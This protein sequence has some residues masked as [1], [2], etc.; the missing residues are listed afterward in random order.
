MNKNPSL[1]NPE[2]LLFSLLS[3]I[4]Q[5]RLVESRTYEFTQMFCCY[6]CYHFFSSTKGKKLIILFLGEKPLCQDGSPELQSSVNPI[7]TGHYLNQ[8]SIKPHGT[9]IILCVPVLIR[10][11]YYLW[12]GY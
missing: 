4:I 1:V 9:G 5:A 12:L 2:V 8:F 3:R 7:E 6:Y 11:K 10:K